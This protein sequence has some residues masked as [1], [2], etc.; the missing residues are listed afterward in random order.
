MNNI[1]ININLKVESKNNQLVG[2][3]ISNHKELNQKHQ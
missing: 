1:N 3:K 2:K